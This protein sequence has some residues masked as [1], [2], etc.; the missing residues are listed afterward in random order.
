MGESSEKLMMALS[1]ASTS[2]DKRGN[3]DN[4]RYSTEVL[5]EQESGLY[6]LFEMQEIAVS[7]NGMLQVVEES[8]D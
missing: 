7:M 6:R 8:I 2:N 3:R 4:R 1:R 5:R